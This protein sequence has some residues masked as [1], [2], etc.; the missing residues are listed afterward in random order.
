MF[1]LIE[2]LNLFAKFKFF[3]IDPEFSVTVKI[4]KLNIQYF[5]ANNQW[6]KG[7]VIEVIIYEKISPNKPIL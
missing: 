1:I 6:D 2:K 3:L 5:S 4:L 7:N